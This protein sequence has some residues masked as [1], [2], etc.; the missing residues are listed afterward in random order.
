[1]TAAA[2][3]TIAAV[4][5]MPATARHGQLAPRQ[6]VLRFAQLPGDKAFKILAPASKGN[7]AAITLRPK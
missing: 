4:P 2:T 3:G 1:M 5:A 6:I 7:H